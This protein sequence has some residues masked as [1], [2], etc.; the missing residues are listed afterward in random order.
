MLESRFQKAT[1]WKYHDRLVNIIYYDHDYLMIDC[2]EQWGVLLPH[3]SR[4]PGLILSEVDSGLNRLCVHWAEF[5]SF[6]P[7]SKNML[8]GGLA[9]LNFPIG[10]NECLWCPAMNG[11]A[12][13][14]AFLPHAK[15][16]WDDEPGWSGSWRWMDGWMNI[17]W[18]WE[19]LL[20]NQNE[21]KLKVLCWN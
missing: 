7:P 5:S 4:V 14:G 13:H 21:E 10:P 8:V 20:L 18:F 11:L 3:R 17:W 12:T 15:W 9:M 1:Q 16:S 6:L 19:T 2:V